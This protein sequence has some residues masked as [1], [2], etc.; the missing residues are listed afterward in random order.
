MCIRDSLETLLDKLHSDIG[1]AARDCVLQDHLKGRLSE[2]DNINGLVVEKGEDLGT[3]TPGN[4][5]IVEITNQIRQGD[6]A[7]N[8]KTFEIA[9]SMIDKLD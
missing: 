6:L 9:K 4:R 5:V 3:A 2:V 1:P 7:P 8:P